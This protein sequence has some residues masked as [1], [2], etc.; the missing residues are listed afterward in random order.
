MRPI[1][2]RRQAR[3]KAEGDNETALESI[4]NETPKLILARRISKA[5]SQVSKGSPLTVAQ[6]KD[7][8]VFVLTYLETHPSANLQE[9]LPEVV[10]AQD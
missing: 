10:S 6:A 5:L 8:L 3:R 9:G 7:V 2:G 4:L 1:S